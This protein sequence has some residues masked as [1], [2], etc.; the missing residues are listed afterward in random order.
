LLS[1]SQSTAAHL[2]SSVSDVLDSVN[3]DRGV[4]RPRLKADLQR[5]PVKGVR[6][7]GCANGSSRPRDCHDIYASGHQEDG[8]YSVYPTHSPAGFQVFC[9]MRTNGGGW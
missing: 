9:D 1:E 8:I 5:A 6:P 4:T 2:V 7:R 3:K